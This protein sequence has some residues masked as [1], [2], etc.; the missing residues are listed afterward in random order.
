MAGA[1]SV[2]RFPQH[3]SAEPVLP[4]C[5]PGSWVDVSMTQ[6]GLLHAGMAIQPG[7]GGRSVMT[8]STLERGDIHSIRDSGRKFR[9]RY[10]P[11]ALV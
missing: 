4:P 2:Q 3:H 5:G 6:A 1:Y 10:Q 9:R 11:G 7:G 8:Y